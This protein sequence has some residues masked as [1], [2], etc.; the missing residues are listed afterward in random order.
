[1]RVDESETQ[2]K[3]KELQLQVNEW[4]RKSEE[5]RRQRDQYDKELGR[6]KCTIADQ[7]DANEKQA[8]ESKP[9]E[10]TSE[11]R[12]NTKCFR[13]GRLGHIARSCRQPAQSRPTNGMQQATGV[14]VAERKECE[15]R[16]ITNN[17][18]SH[19]ADDGPGTYLKC[20]I[21]GDYYK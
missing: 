3:M 6:L 19:N 1:M 17:R 8:H 20:R 12:R 21:N 11:P 13:C 2:D 16:T 14:T 5:F 18:S 15:T 7:P 10:S 4:Q 9:E